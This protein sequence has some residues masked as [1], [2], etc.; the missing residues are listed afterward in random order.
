MLLA[1][2]DSPGKLAKVMEGQ[3]RKAEA[4]SLLETARLNRAYRTT[5]TP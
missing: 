1:A 5:V 3:T 4:F 2:A